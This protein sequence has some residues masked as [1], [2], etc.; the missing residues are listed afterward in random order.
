MIAAALAHPNIAFIK[1]WGNRDHALRL[2]SNGSI[3]MNLES[4]E[5]RT[6]VEFRDPLREDTLEVNG[7]PLTGPALERV[8]IF[9]D[10]VRRL[11][12]E[13]RHAAIVSR[14]NFP[15]GAGIASSAAAF[16]ALALAGSAAAGLELSE[17]ELS[18]LA[19]LGSGSACRSVPE[20]FCEW[21]ASDSDED[22]V[23]VSIA[24]AGHWDLRDL[25]V[26]V[27]AGHKKV[28]STAGHAMAE[29]SPYQT[30]RVK[31]APERLMDCRNAILKKD[32]ARLAE[33]SEKDQVMMHAV[34]M[35]QTPPLF[36][37]EGTSLAIQKSIRE[38]R[39]SEGLQCFATLDAG[40]NVHVICE[41]AYADELQNRLRKFP[42][43]KDI[44]VS[45]PGGKAVLL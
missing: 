11:S 3:S 9:M 6:T 25:I 29:T 13:E 37:W 19:R 39:E 1:Y 8:R 42:D 43:V 18:R 33:V 23:S 31:T 40:P 41:A 44:L 38:W 36:Y 4:L 5:T 24:P 16:S 32:F 20:G 7:Q 27:D 28:G 12:G 10:E 45:A 26:L 21:L 34:M 35:T 14:N 17:E 22:S 2:P 15:M 30:A